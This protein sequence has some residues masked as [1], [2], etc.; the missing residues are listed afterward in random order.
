MK[1]LAIV[2]THPIQYYAPV[3]KLLTD[4]NRIDVKVF[5][6]LGEEQSTN[7]HDAGFGRT[8]EWDLPLLTGYAWRFL[9]NVSRRPGTE[10]FS[11]ICNPDAI[12]EISAYAPDA[13][14][15]Y[16]WSN[17]SH[18]S[19]IKYFK[20]KIPVIFRGDSTML[21]Q[22]SRFKGFF[23]KLFLKW[24]YRHIHRALYV[25]SAN[26]QYFLELGVSHDRLI[27]CPHAI[28]NDRFSKA[29]PAEVLKL[30]R[31]L[32][33]G[34]EDRLVLFAGKLE[35]KKNPAVLLQAISDLKLANVHLL[36]MGNGVLQIDLKNRFGNCRNIHFRNF[37]N[38]SKMPV[39]YH[40]CDVFCLPSRGPGETWGLAVNEAMAAGKA[41]IVSTKVG[42]AADLV[43][44]ENGLVFET[45]CLSSLKQALES[46][47][48]N[49]DKLVVMG[50]N[51][52]RIISRWSFEMQVVAI[53]KVVHE[54]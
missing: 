17:K 13:I 41:V 46:I 50:E 37:E 24:V 10:R 15:I 34:S 36:V 6:T 32:G 9:K 44:E 52:A 51:S 18:L 43:R 42:C 16:G 54:L 22:Q 3:F 14:L 4:R 53:E 40:A 31:E 1:K 45:E 23:R 11:G 30:R 33:L 7:K 35:P 20:N 27:F 19:L 28:D 2:C 8:I 29:N 39:I 21:D 47:L 12:A 5:Y 25:G 38:Q 49:K 26:K 48:N